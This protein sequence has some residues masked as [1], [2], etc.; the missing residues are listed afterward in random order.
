M[1]GQWAAVGEKGVR[2]T[3]DT[4]TGGRTTFSR[5]L[6]TLRGQRWEKERDGEAA[7]S[8]RGTE[9]S[10]TAREAVNVLGACLICA[11]KNYPS[12]S[13]EIVIMYAQIRLIVRQCTVSHIHPPTHPSAVSDRY[14]QQSAIVPVSTRPTFEH[15]P[16]TQRTPTTPPP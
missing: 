12:L 11:S 13:S 8:R 2:H 6:L 7:T 15:V 5:L 14:Q 9:T 1:G 4:Q 16:L 3:R 10:V